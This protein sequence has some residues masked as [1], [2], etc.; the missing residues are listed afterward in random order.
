MFPEI[1]S[2]RLTV[3]ILVRGCIPYQVQ[4]VGLVRFGCDFDVERTWSIKATR[5]GSQFRAPSE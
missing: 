2:F 5:H 4:I 1:V 3:F